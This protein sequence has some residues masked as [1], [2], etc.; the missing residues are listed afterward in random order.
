[1][2]DISNHWV[3]S[4]LVTISEARGHWGTRVGEHEDRSGSGKECNPGA[5][6]SYRVITFETVTIKGH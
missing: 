6:L 5:A 4:A 3:T 2:P 1:M